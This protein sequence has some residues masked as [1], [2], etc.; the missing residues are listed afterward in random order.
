MWEIKLYKTLL[1]A[2]RALDN[3]GRFYNLFARSGDDIVDQA[4]LAKAA[5]VYSAGVKAFLQFEMKTMDLPPEQK[6]EI[7]TWLSPELID[8]YIAQRPAVLKPSSVESQGHVDK[9]TIV[10]GYPIFM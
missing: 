9:V 10:S 8:K 4:E 6:D 3:S 5:G 1:G 7:T 2:L